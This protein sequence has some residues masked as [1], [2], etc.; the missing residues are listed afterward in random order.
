MVWFQPNIDTIFIVNHIL[1]LLFVNFFIVD[2][3]VVIFVFLHV[4]CSLLRTICEL[5]GAEENGEHKT[6][7]INYNVIIIYLVF[8]KKK[9]SANFYGECKEK[10]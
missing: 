8:Y 9:K 10:K 2:I 3:N 4:E 6:R 5:N 7:P 1:L